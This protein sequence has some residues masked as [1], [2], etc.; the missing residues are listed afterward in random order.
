MLQKHLGVNP[1]S[2]PYAQAMQLVREQI[3]RWDNKLCSFK[4][5]KVLK[6]YGYSTE[7][8]FEQASATI[9]AL[10]KNNWQ[11]VPVAAPLASGP[12]AT[13]TQAA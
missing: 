5:A 1:D 11:C 3:R 8:T 9:D 10:A 12:P 7:V 2:I 6:K 4:Q 13:E